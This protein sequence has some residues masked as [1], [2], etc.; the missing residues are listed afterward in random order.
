MIM[1]RF[2]D[3]GCALAGLALSALLIAAAPAIAQAPANEQ[4]PADGQ[5]VP[6]F[7]GADG[8]DP[9]RWYHVL[10]FEEG[11]MGDITR[12]VYDRIEKS[13]A[14][15]RDPVRLD[16]VI[17]YGPGHWTYEWEQEAAA[18][19]ARGRAAEQAGDSAAAEQAYLNAAQLFS[20]GSSPH[21]RSD[22]YAMAS[23]EKARAAYRQGAKH[24]RGS[25]RVLEI[26]YEG[27]TFEAYL[28]L[29]P[30]N[31]PFP[32]V[33]GSNGTDV[34]KEEVSAILRREL[35]GR[36]IALLSLDMP[37]IG[38]SG[39]YDLTPASEVLHAAAINFIRKDPG[40]DPNRVAAVGTSFGGHAAARLALR[41]DL[42][43][44]AVVSS[45]GPLHS[46]FV[47]PPQMY[48]RLPP[49]TMD[50]VRDRMGLPIGSSSTDLAARMRGFSLKTNPPEQGGA[51]SPTP[52]LILTNHDDPVAPIADLPLLTDR[53]R[54]SKTL[55]SHE[56]GHCPDPLF[57][58]P[59]A[60]FW[61]AQ[62][63]AEGNG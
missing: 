54:S 38:G 21:I 37:G 11:P 58:A 18:F 57:S 49:L 23:L 53:V 13:D 25:F 41:P 29:P 33:I 60:V 8:P 12:G 28:H 44:V 6:S 43:L 48:D 1:R 4:P 3:R 2:Q 16:T 24:F 63:L 55:I 36:G 47:A 14:P 40:I 7:H 61:L 26:P 27:K 56:Q 17:P 45:C 10:E 42:L 15:R 51:R 30:G 35:A 62:Q 32:V 5:A 20:I 50:A 19:L 22:T 9:N 46:A 39:A 31:G 34:V 52:L 59:A